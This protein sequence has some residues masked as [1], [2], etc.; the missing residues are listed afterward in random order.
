MIENMENVFSIVF[1]AFWS[2]LAS[3][4][5]IQSV[6]VLATLGSSCS[7]FYGRNE[8]IWLAVGQWLTGILFAVAWVVGVDHFQPEAEAFLVGLASGG[9]IRPFIQAFASR[10]TNLGSKLNV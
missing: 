7:T 8:R 9:A 2:S 3:F 5:P 1:Y 10:F 6:W 4:E